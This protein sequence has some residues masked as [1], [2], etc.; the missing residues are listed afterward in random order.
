MEKIVDYIFEMGLQK[1]VKRSGW[2]VAGVKDPETIGE[3]SQRAAMIAYILAELEGANPDKSALI[4]MIHD[5][6]ECRINDGHK[7]ANRYLDLKKGEE[8]AM[9]DQLA[10]LP[11]KIAGR[12]NTIFK[13]YLDQSSKEGII[14]KDADYLECAFQAK[15][16]IDIG[17]AS[18]EDWINNVEKSLKT[19]SARK[20]LKI[21]RRTDSKRWFTGL[22]KIGGR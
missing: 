12:F 4:C 20:L 7:I 18:T 17:Y 15:E 6:P 1:H 13:E 10:L 8:L 19:E 11:E 5:I 16:Y 22:K 21:L 2:W 9:K 3:H 14:A